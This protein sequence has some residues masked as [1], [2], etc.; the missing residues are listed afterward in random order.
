MKTKQSG[1]TIIVVIFTTIITLL[2]IIP[3]YLSRINSAKEQKEQA[4]KQIEEVE[5]KVQDQM[6]DGLEENLK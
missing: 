2:F 5:R 6:N 4:K 3:L 1:F